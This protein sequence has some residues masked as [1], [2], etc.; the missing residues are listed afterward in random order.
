MEAK[1]MNGLTLAYIGDTIY[2]T[3][4][5][6]MNILKGIT[7]VNDLHKHTIKYTCAEYQ[8]KGASYL[9]KNDILS[10]DEL[11]MFKR[12]RN[13]NTN[14]TRKSLS[15]EDYNNATGLEALMGYLYFIDKLDRAYEIIGIIVENIEA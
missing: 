10:E 15:I 14:K 5:R 9:L 2:E 1:L 3:Y 6:K 13:S 7:K 12:G 11:A 8:A 4:I